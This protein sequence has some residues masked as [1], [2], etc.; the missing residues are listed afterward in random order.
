MPRLR[1]WCLLSIT[2]SSSRSTSDAEREENVWSEPVAEIPNV[3]R[4]RLSQYFRNSSRTSFSTR[5]AYSAG[6]SS[7]IGGGAGGSLA[8][9]N[10]SMT[11]RARGAYDA[12]QSYPIP[13]ENVVPPPELVA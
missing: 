2:P 5:F 11:N 1:N 8:Q 4:T 3:L 13:V 9:L 10:S 7:P 12:L 6:V